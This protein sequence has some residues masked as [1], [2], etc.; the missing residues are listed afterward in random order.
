MFWRNKRQFLV[1]P[2]IIFYGFSLN[3]IV[4]K[5]TLNQTKHYFIFQLVFHI[6]P[7]NYLYYPQG[8]SQGGSLGA[9]DKVNTFKLCKIGKIGLGGVFPP[10]H[11]IWKSKY[12]PA[13]PTKVTW[14][15]KGR[16]GN[17]RRGTEDRE[18]REPFYP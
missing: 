3:N 13:T 17:S 11:N 8:R 15:G 16:N 6:F 1:C 18:G 12:F 5:N 14:P 2:Y 4:K 10:I 7:F 9:Y